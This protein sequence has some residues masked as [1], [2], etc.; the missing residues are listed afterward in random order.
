MMPVMDGATLAAS[1]AQSSPGIP[2]VAMSGLAGN[3][4]RADVTS[5]SA[6]LA[7]PF[8]TADLIRT[9]SHWVSP[10]KGDANG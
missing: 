5:M 6:F 8:S 2:I 7:K 9:V 1:L 4:D 10:A 3:A